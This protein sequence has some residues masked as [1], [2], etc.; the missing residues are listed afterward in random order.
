[1]MLI[2]SF[3]LPAFLI[4][5]FLMFFQISGIH[6]FLGDQQGVLS[7]LSGIVQS[8][9]A[10]VAIV[11]SIVTLA[12]QVT[13][14]K[15]VSKAAK[16]LILSPSNLMILNL[17]VYTIICSLLAMWIMWIALVDTVILMSILC[18]CLLVPFF[19]RAPDFLNPLAILKNVRIEILD[20]CDRKDDKETKKKVEF[21]FHIITDS[22][23][24]RELESSLEGIETIELLVERESFVYPIEQGG[25]ETREPQFLDFVQL[26]LRRLCL[27]LLETDPG[28]VLRLLE[29][30]GVIVRKALSSPYADLLNL[31]NR[32]SISLWEVCNASIPRG[33]DRESYNMDVARNIA[34]KSYDLMCD[35]Y[36]GIAMK[37][38][39]IAYEVLERLQKVVVFCGRI[40][41]PIGYVLPRS[42]STAMRLLKEHKQTQAESFLGVIL[43]SVITSY[44]QSQY[45]VQSMKYYII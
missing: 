1:M 2:F 18:I 39:P 32:L 20:S 11:F 22:Y 33:M 31:G 28:L 23:R 24:A 21:L 37:E 36:E 30:Y 19:I 3:C 29:T 9:S 41:V 16:Y 13:I 35:I 17:F 15:Y 4:A 6:I 10:V 44:Q 42:N 14:G 25:L 12:V 27:Y 43:N 8:L 26:S 5:F 7:V 45:N 34:L 38:H 40:D